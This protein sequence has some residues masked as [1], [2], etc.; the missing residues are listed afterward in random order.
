MKWYLF[1]ETRVI[2]ELFDGHRKYDQPKSVASA[3]A[4]LLARS[5]APV[6]LW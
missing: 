6:A 2:G 4:V 5:F 3:V 1:D